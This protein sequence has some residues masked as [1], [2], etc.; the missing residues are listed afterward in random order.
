[1]NKVNLEIQYFDDC[2]NSIEFIDRIKQ[3]RESGEI[4]NYTYKETLVN[5]NEMAKQIKFRGSP[6]LLING[7]DLEEMEAPG[8]PGLNCR[9]Y[10]NGLPDIDEIKNKIKQ[11][12]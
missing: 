2:P 1:M 7:K 10:P 11:L 6:T 5:S 9:F 3:I 12:A 8:N 4:A